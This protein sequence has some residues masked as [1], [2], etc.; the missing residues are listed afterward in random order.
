M[1]LPKP[2]PNTF[3]KFLVTT[4]QIFKTILIAFTIILVGCSKFEKSNTSI[5]GEITGLKKG[6]LYL[7]QIKNNQYINIDSLTLDN[8]ENFEF[9]LNL[10]E[11]D[12]YLLRLKE[13]PLDEILIFVEKGDNQV[14]TN[15]V[16][17]L[18]DLKITGSENQTILDQ[19]NSYIQ[20][21]SNR[22]ADYIKEKLEALKNKNVAK[23][24]EMVTKHQHNLKR[25]LLFTINY[26]HLY[27]NHEVAPYIALTKIENGSPALL[28]GIYNRLTPKIQKSKYGKMLKKYIISIS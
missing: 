22:N 4:M 5:T 25:V 6:T 7:S 23:A 17:Y 26:V 3:L 9:N 1:V 8:E 21:E 14:K 20:K 12:V 19:Y 18:S 2:S 24:Q 13:R 10:N 15:L 28:N 27:N 11:P 16:N